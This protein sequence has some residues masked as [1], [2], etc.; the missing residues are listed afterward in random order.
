MAPRRSCSS[1]AAALRLHDRWSAGAGSWRND[2][3][4]L[5]GNG[6]LSSW[7][8]WMAWTTCGS[9]HGALG[10]RRPKPPRSR[11]IG[12][13]DLQSCRCRGSWTSGAG[14]ARDGRPTGHATAAPLLVLAIFAWHVFLDRLFRERL[15]LFKKLSEYVLS[16]GLGR[17]GGAA[18]Q[19]G[20][21]D[22]QAST[23]LRWSAL[24]TIGSE[25]AFTFYVDVM[26]FLNFIGTASDPGL[27]SDL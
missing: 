1:I 7:L 18:R 20:A 15:T 23:W 17:D 4:P 6:E 9:G 16:A 13:R 24:L 3:P 22:R 5:R 19:H 8:A 21:L 12:W 26:G 11:R 25:V 10:G 14:F 2:R 27:R